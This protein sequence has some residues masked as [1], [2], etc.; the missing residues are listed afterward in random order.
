MKNI[1]S[2]KEKR[3]AAFVEASPTRRDADNSTKKRGSKDAAL[4]QEMQKNQIPKSDDEGRQRDE[5][6]FSSNF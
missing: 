2:E 5:S 3:A 1:Y 6:F 4:L